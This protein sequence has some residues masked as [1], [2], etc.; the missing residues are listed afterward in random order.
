[1]DRRHR[2]EGVITQVKIENYRGEKGPPNTVSIHIRFVEGGAQNFGGL[3][4]PSKIEIETYLSM[5]C[6]TFGVK[7]WKDLLGQE[8]YALR[9][10]SGWNEP[11]HGLESV[12]TGRKF[13]NNQFRKFME[14]PHE[15]MIIEEKQRLE[16]RIVN[17]ENDLQRF[18]KDLDDLKKN[19]VEWD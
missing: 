9:A 13:T 17:A 12:T 10:F 11:I 6:L 18:R 8:C 16:R 1:M 14:Y 7:E 2:E 4:I 19:Y 3:M 5:V 15:S